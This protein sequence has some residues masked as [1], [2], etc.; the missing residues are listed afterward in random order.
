MVRSLSKST[1]ASS[2]TVEDF[3]SHFEG[4]LNALARTQMVLTRSAGGAVNLDLLVRE[5]LLA[6]A[7]RPQQ[8]D[9]AGPEVFLSA[10]AAEVLALAVHELATNSIKYG[11]LST[12]DGRVD[13]RW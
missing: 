13:V 11:A 4:R 10:K 3:T 12:S 9:V 1:A 5:E 7:A 2:E 6:Q 8:V